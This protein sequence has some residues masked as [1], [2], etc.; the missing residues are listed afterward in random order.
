MRGCFRQDA[1]VEVLRLPLSGSLRMTIVA[2]SIG[3]YLVH[4]R[5]SARLARDLRLAGRYIAGAG[6]ALTE[7][8][9]GAS[10]LCNEIA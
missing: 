7:A 8:A 4:G 9:G 3:K 10:L 6:S 1:V 5:S 2:N